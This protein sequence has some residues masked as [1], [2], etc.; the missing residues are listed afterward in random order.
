MKLA[1]LG[2]SITLGYALEQREADRFPAV[3][4]R[5]TGH[6]EYN[7]GITGTL[8]ARA[9]LSASDGTAYVDRYPQMAGA[10]YAIVFGGTNDYFWSDAPISGGEGDAYFM[11]AVHTLCRGLLTMFPKEKILFL[12]PYPHHGIGNFAGGTHWRE[13]SEHDTD[14]VNFVGHVLSDYGD[15]ICGVCAEYGI[16]VLDL[17]S[18]AEPFDWRAMTIDGCHP[19]EAGHVWLAERIREVLCNG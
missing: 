1:F 6:E 5:M 7:L 13:S 3:L 10:D 15:V 16:A 14:D 4:C 2:D 9:G 19:N 12:T 11:N 8:V 18:C 17:R